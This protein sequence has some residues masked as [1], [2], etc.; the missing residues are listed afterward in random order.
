MR[1]TRRQWLGRG[2]TG[3]VLLGF[4]GLLFDVWLGARR[5]T[6]AHWTP[7]TDLGSLPGDGVFP[8]PAHKVALLLEQGRL[9]VISLECTHLGCLVNVEDDG[10]FCPCHGS[11]F[12]PRGQV[13]SGPAPRALPWHPLRI[14]GSRVWFF[15]GEKIPSPEW[16]PVD[17]AHPGNS[18]G[19]T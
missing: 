3:L 7:L 9:A 14:K 11:D 15:S 18:E 2:L 8:F 17:T 19:Q 10:F 13:Y 1:L 5:F 4:G 12:G 16:L 6:S